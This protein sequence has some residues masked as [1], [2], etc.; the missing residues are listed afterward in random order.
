[1]RSSREASGEVM[2]LRGGKGI[3]QQQK[4]W[5]GGHAWERAAEAGD[6]M[7]E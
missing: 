5:T 3:C 7:T 6:A 1:M 2:R 4:E